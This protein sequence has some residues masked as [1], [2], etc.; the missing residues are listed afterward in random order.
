MIFER[1]RSCTPTRAT[2]GSITNVRTAS[3]ACSPARQT[4]YSIPGR[5]IPSQPVSTVLS[6]LRI[7]NWPT[8]STCEEDPLAPLPE[9]VTSDRAP[10]TP[11]RH[12]HH[13][14]DIYILLTA[15]LCSGRNPALN[16]V[17][18]DDYDSGPGGERR[19]AT[20][21]VP[22]PAHAT[23]PTRREAEQ[24]EDLLK[25]SQLAL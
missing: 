4:L 3:R 8:A 15:L 24:R 22:F 21:S 14:A 17:N 13:T 25:A 10:P 2:A 5:T 12:T 16:T 6:S 20:P 23:V 11:P 9:H 1:S 7:C 19:P 18:I